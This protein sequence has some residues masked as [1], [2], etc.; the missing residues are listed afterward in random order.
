MI[1]GFSKEVLK[2]ELVKM[3]KGATEKAQ[4][5]LIHELIEMSKPELNDLDYNNLI[6]F[7]GLEFANK[8]IQ[9]LSIK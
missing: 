5:S 2:L 3:I 6:T 1:F 8:D 4:F 9:N 7:L